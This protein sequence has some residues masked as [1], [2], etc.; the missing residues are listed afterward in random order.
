MAYRVLQIRRDSAADWTSANPTLKE[1]ELGWETDTGL[2]KIGDGSTAW[3]SLAYFSNY[4]IACKAYLASDQTANNAT[5]YK[6]TMDT[7]DYDT[8]SAFDTT[9]NKYVIPEDG[10]YHIILRV[11]FGT[12]TIDGGEYNIR[13]FVNGVQ[14]QATTLVMGNGGAAYWADQEVHLLKELS[15]DD[16]VEAYGRNNSGS[17]CYFKG[18]VAVTNIVLARLGA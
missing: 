18:G 2:L 14:V 12:T 10:I 4:T 3:T 15:A 11:R 9:N 16:Y 6:I 1:G 13:I 7:V 17:N 5:L 8:D